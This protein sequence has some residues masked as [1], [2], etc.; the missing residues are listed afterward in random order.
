MPSIVFLHSFG[1]KESKNITS[2]NGCATCTTL[3]DVRWCSLALFL[4]IFTYSC[5]QS[6]IF[7]LNFL[8]EIACHKEFWARKEY[9]MLIKI[10]IF[11]KENFRFNQCKNIFM[12]QLTVSP[13]PKLL[14]TTICIGIIMVHFVSDLIDDS[15]LYL[16]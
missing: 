1:K 10:G 12:R 16:L 5:T 2:V 9:D 8:S 3:I 4:Y 15:S 13:N 7:L 11:S 6:F 14:Y